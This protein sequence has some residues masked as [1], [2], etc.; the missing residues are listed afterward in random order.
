MLED[1]VG[2]EP[3]LVCWTQLYNCFET[4][5]GKLRATPYLHAATHP[6]SNYIETESALPLDRLL[7]SVCFLRILCFECVRQT[8]LTVTHLPKY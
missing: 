5:L 3:V 1:G 7:M 2:G 6:C 4:P 8:L